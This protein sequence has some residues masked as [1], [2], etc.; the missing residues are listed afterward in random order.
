MEKLKKKKLDVISGKQTNSKIQ[1]ILETCRHMSYFSENI[2]LS[3]WLRLKMIGKIFQF[4]SLIYSKNLEFLDQK[5]CD[6]NS[7]KQTN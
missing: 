2:L 5:F 3:F 1:K 6:V 7:G 4:R